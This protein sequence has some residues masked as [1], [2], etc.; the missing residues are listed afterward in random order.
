MVNFSDYIINI[1]NLKHNVEKVR[2]IC[3]NKKVC[4]VVKADGYG[5][6]I[7]N[8][9][10]QIEDIVDMFA[11]ATFGEALEVR[12]LTSKPILI[13]NFVPANCLCLCAE[14]NLIVSVYSMEHLKQIKK[15][16]SNRCLKV[17]IAINSGMN[18]IGVNNL[19]ELEKM[20]QYIE[21]NK[22]IVN[23]NGIFTHFYKAANAA[24]TQK[25][26]QIFM[27]YVKLLKKRY[28]NIIA[29]CSA[30]VATVK[31]K[32]YM[33]DMVRLGI[34]MY[35]A[36]KCN[37]VNFKPVVEVKSRVIDIKEIKKGE[38]VGYEKKFIAPKK[39]TIATIPLGYADGIFRNYAKKGRVLIKGE[40]C[41]IVG[42]I[43]MDMFMVDVSNLDVSVGDNVV[44]IGSQKSKK[45]EMTDVAKACGTISYEILTS[46][47]KNRFNVVL[48]NN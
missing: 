8:F 17:Q 32:K 33:L 12:K 11:V 6:G 45:I 27:Q 20:L 14:N 24:E 26:F 39:M 3:C 9:V 47:N 18:R 2:Q 46:L 40:Y 31:Y 5:I 10:N 7:T 48:K 37:S 28:K 13:L 19:Q 34:Y 15:H 36:E 43:C 42:N 4:A 16:T 38:N 22:L 23:I 1:K 25:Q 29:H 30:S 21:T 41:K 35:G 44:L